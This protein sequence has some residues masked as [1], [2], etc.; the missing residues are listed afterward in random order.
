MVDEVVLADEGFEASA[1]VRREIWPTAEHGGNR[2][3]CLSR[4]SQH[5]ERGRLELKFA[6]TDSSRP[7]T[8]GFYLISLN[9]SRSDGLSGISGR[10][11]RSVGQ[12]RARSGLAALMKLLKTNLEAAHSGR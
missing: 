4:A 2:V 6:V 3:S 9:R 11:M 7:T 1:R 10:V 12:S 5:A 8:E